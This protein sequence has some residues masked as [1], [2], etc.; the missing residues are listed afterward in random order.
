MAQTKLDGIA[1]SINVPN[2]WKIINQQYGAV[3][4]G[5]DELPG[6]IM[7]VEHGFTSSSTLISN[8][9]T[10]LNDKD[11]QMI[12]IGNVN[13]LSNGAQQATLQG[14]MYGE[15]VKAVS[16][17]SFSKAW[18]NGG[19]M[20]L[21]AVRSDLYN[22]S[23]KDLTLSIGK[24][25][26]YHTLVDAKAK[27]WSTVLKGKMF[28]NYDSYSSYDNY[29]NGTSIGGSYNNKT[30]IHLCS[31]GQFSISCNGNISAGSSVWGGTSQS[32][33][34]ESGKW[35]PMTIKEVPV[36]RFVYKSGSVS[37]FPLE[38]GGEE[39][40]IYANGTK[41]AVGNSNKCQ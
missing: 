1:V 15:N 8:L 35:Q 19:V 9:K 12:L 7:L 23:Y 39:G 32:S 30:T 13:T 18:G 41:Y 11:I 6:M 27:Q 33:N 16:Y 28:V 21:A 29:D 34:E 31:N 5:N 26:K 3:I 37:Y 17:S 20:V 24:L 25:I 38:D 10:G 22:D 2:G 36:L 4:L 40:Y 14:V